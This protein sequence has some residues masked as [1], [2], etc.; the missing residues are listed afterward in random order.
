MKA[1]V[2]FTYPRCNNETDAED[3]LIAVR[4]ELL[5]NGAELE[6]D[7][8]VRGLFFDVVIDFPVVPVIGDVITIELNQVKGPVIEF[9]IAG[10]HFRKNYGKKDYSIEIYAQY[11][12]Y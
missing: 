4:D 9:E 6:L 2:T 11:N 7:E 8:I 3:L 1:I 12:D 10:R 5:N